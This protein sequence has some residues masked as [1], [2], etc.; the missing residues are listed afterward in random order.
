MQGDNI[1]KLYLDIAKQLL[2]VL[3]ALL[4]AVLVLLPVVG[5]T[6]PH[7]GGEG[8]DLSSVWDVQVHRPFSR[9]LMAQHMTT[10][11]NKRTSRLID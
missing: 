6:D 10:Y 8:E 1:T 4:L 9:R 2:H 11:D 3:V 7:L 5:H